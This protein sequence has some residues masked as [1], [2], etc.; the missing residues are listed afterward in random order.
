[1]TPSERPLL[2]VTIGTDPH[3][4]SRLIEWVDRW[5][6]DHQDVDAVIQHST[7]RAP[8]RGNPVAYLPFDQLQHLVSEASIVVCHAGTIVSECRR[9]GVVPVVV[10]RRRHLGEAVDDHQIRFARFAALDGTVVCC[11]TEQDLRGELTRR[12][13]G[14]GPHRRAATRTQQHRAPPGIERAGRELDRLLRAPHRGSDSQVNHGP[15]PAAH[16]TSRVL[17]IGG[18]ERSGTTLLER[19]LGEFPDVQAVGELAHIWRRG[20]VND[21]LCSCGA[22]FSR[23]AFWNAVGVDAFGGWDAPDVYRMLSLHR[24]LDRTRRIR[25][26]AGRE[27]TPALSRAVRDYDNGYLRVYEAIR[28]VSGASVVVDSSKRASLA[29]CLKWSERVDLRVVHMIRDGRAVAHSWSR[30]VARPEV[31]NGEAAFMPRYGTLRAALLW[32]ASNALFELLAARGVPRVVVHYEDLVREPAA[33]LAGVAA[34]AGIHPPPAALSFVGDALA[35]LTEGHSISGNPMRFR[36]GSVPVIEDVSWR[37]A[38]PM[39]T[40]RMISA[41]T[42]PGMSRYGYF[43]P[44]GPRPDHGSTPENDPSRSLRGTVTGSF[45]DRRSTGPLEER[46]GTLS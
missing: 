14:G 26:L 46:E 17:F 39:S 45:G 5:V 27:L 9:L 7:S 33:V 18:A 20:V 11:E 24:W 10:P 2:L 40:R 22:R 4:F 3:P 29:F 1:V 16:G 35:T 42:Y 44:G 25:R 21:E 30:V 37:S 36:A 19:M 34:F 23:C 43:A 13:A 15:Q 41:L 31:I 6:A 28:R 38:M 32:N 12:W 8:T